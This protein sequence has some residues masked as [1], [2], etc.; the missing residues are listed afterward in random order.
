MQAGKETALARGAAPRYRPN[1]T[2]HVVLVAA[3]PNV[4]LFLDGQ[5]TGYARTDWVEP[6]QLHFVVINGGD[7]LVAYRIDNVALW[8]LE[9][10]DSP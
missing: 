2:T 7:P 8:S 4:A 10:E 5:P 1:T 9:A 3:G 6:G